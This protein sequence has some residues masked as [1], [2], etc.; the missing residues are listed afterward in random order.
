MASK[1]WKCL[2]PGCPNR[3]NDP[4][5]QLRETPANTCAG[6]GRWRYLPHALAAGV[7]GV[8]LAA[9]GGIV[10]L[11]G[12]PARNYAGK[13]ALCLRNDGRID[14]QE[15]RELA[16]LAEK[17]H[18]DQDALA[19]LQDEVRQQLGFNAKPAPSPSATAQPVTPA[20]TAAL[21]EAPR[22]LA[23]LL[24]NIYSDHLKS[25][26][27][28]ELLNAALARQTLAPATGAQLEQ[29]IKAR[30]A[31]AQPYFERGLTA[32]RQAR[33]QTA[34]EEFQRALVEDADNAWILA[35]LG[36]AYLQAGRLEDAE[37]SCQRALAFDAGNWLAHYNLGS[38]YAKHGRKDA[39]LGALQQALQ[40]AATDR[41]QPITRAE[42]IGQLRTDAALSALRQDARFQQLL[43]R[44]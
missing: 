25:A 31:A 12:L 27:E 14:D 40:C 36:A 16:K 42:I 28:Q 3:F 18:L 22:G 24:H 9:G 43:A 6:C 5:E 21:T 32:A 23:A 34:I 39:A 20:S 41:T 19:Q 35:N 44:N 11:T 29:T 30:W 17:Y 13:Y 38:V 4:G 8:M 26:E 15:E 2:M 1:A 7:L 37:A 10:W 33:A